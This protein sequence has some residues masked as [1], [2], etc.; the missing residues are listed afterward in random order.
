MSDCQ[1]ICAQLF[2]PACDLASRILEISHPADR[3]I[4]CSQK[5]R[6]TIEITVKRF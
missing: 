5:Y 1:I 3:S 6:L 2:Q 4:V